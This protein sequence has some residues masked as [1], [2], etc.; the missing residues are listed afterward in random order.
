MFAKSRQLPRLAVV[1]FLVRLIAET[2]QVPFA[3]GALR[4]VLSRPNVMHSCRLNFSAVS[5]TLAAKVSVSP[6]DP[7]AQ[8]NPAPVTAAVVKVCFACHGLATSIV[9][10]KQKARTSKQHAFPLRAFTGPGS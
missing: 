4:I 2:E 8:L 9:Q 3:V 1:H 7:L 5:L 6:Q 10:A